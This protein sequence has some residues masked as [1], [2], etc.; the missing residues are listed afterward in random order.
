MRKWSTFSALVLVQ[1]Y[2][3]WKENNK[4][5]VFRIQGPVWIL[6]FSERILEFVPNMHSSS[7]PVTYLVVWLSTVHV[8]IHSLKKS[9]I[10]S[11]EIIVAPCVCR[12]PCPRRWTARTARTHAGGIWSTLS[13]TP[14]I[15]TCVSSSAY[16]WVTSLAV[17]SHR[18][19]VSLHWN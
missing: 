5:Q 12:A 1:N 9:R 19:V 14:H 3:S 7:I 2:K 17:M 4:T 6:S 13:K 18:L 11:E 16:R 8:F 10:S 15:G